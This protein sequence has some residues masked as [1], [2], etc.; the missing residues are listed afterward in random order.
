MGG[1]YTSSI[2]RGVEVVHSTSDLTLYYIML[3]PSSNRA[4]VDP[5]EAVR[6]TDDDAAASRSWVP[7]LLL[8]LPSILSGEED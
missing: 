8:S 2:V 7:C 1:V 3:P 4:Q 5:D 6:S